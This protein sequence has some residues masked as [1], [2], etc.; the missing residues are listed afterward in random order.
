MYAKTLPPEHLNVGIA[1]VR[2][3]RALERQSRSTQ[4]VKESQAGYDIL[5]KQSH[6]PV[7]WLQQARAD[8]IEEYMRLKEPQKAA[9]FQAE[10][11]EN[12]QSAEAGKF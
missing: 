6:P 5:E 11:A 3:G 1:R 7:A 2:L 12:K 9:K 10:L 8:L 4:A